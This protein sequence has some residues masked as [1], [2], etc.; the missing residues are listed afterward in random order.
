[1]SFVDQL[2]GADC[3]SIEC[4]N[5]FKDA[6]DNRH[7]PAVFRLGLLEWQ[8]VALHADDAAVMDSPGGMPCWLTTTL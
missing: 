7:A 1:V 8:R 4:L 3:R 2:R 6:F 5:A